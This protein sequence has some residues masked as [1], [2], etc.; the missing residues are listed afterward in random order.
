MTLSQSDIDSLL[1][2]QQSGSVESL[3]DVPVSGQDISVAL[4]DPNFVPT[5]E[6]FDLFK[7]YNKTKQTDWVNTI[8]QSVD[9]AAGMIGSALSQ[10]AQGAAVNPLNYI[11]GAAQGT[12]QMYGL[13]AQSENPDS[14]LFKFKDLLTGTGTPDSQYNQF[15]EARDFA[16][17]SQRL[18]KGEQGLVVPPELTNP[19]F[20]QGVSMI[21]DPTLLLPGIG[22]VF[23]G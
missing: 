9:A 22:E 7:E 20:V 18:E 6:Q 11:E 10:G 12:R 19:E 4:Q 23:G 17:T 14:P 1:G 15:L 3:L 2:P 8:A 21:A 5:R 16:R 13:V